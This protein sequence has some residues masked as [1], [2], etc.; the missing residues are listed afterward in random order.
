MGG[1]PIPHSA[2][3]SLVGASP[4]KATQVLGREGDIRRPLPPGR[5]GFRLLNPGK[6]PGSKRSVNVLP[7]GCGFKNWE[8][9]LP[10]SLFVLNRAAEQPPLAEV[11]QAWADAPG[12]NP[13]E[14]VNDVPVLATAAQDL[15]QNRLICAYLDDLHSE[16]LTRLRK[17]RASRELADPLNWWRDEDDPAVPH[18]DH[19]IVLDITDQGQN[20][21]ARITY[22][23][24][25][26]E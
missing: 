25:A 8:G 10:P 3:R 4:E 16:E 18:A 23:E 24:G 9:R 15:I 17:R 6:M 5:N 26:A 13:G 11:L 20:L 12:R 14:Y 1:G 2:L 7:G 22:T 21:L 19:L